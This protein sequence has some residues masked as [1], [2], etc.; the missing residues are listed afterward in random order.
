MIYVQPS[1]LK[2]LMEIIDRTTGKPSTETPQKVM[3]GKDLLSLRELSREVPLAQEIKEYAAKLVL[4]TAPDHRLSSPTAK[5]YLRYGASPRAAQSIILT[6]KVKA[7]MDNRLNVSF[8]DVRA[9]A[10][11]ALRHRIIRNFECEAEGISPDVIVRKIIEET[12][13]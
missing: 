2:E 10:I 3:D 5:R 12:E 1:E 13:R 8:E 7:L 11:P 4:M 9:T 6:S